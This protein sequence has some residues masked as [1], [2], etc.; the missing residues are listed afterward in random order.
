MLGDH[1]HNARY[2]IVHKLGNGGYSTVWLAHDAQLEKF[3]ALEIGTA[4]MIFIRHDR[5]RAHH[6]TRFRGQRNCS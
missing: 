6:T 1:I 4:S 5:E 2:R 3:V